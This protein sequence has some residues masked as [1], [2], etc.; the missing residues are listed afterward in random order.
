MS[1]LVLVTITQ[2]LN[3]IATFGPVAV[4]IAMQF[5]KLFSGSNST[6]PFEVQIQVL[7]DG[8]LKNVTETDAIWAKWTAE[9]PDV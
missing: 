7:E 8:I 3:L 1:P 6:V 4:G 2:G 5:K 9:H